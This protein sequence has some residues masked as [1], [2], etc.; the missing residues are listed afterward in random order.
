MNHT[1]S[2]VIFQFDE[3]ELTQLFVEIMSH[4]AYTGA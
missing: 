3:N 4:L 2:D 1:T